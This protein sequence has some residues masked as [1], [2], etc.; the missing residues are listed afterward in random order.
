[1]NNPSQK[2][3]GKFLGEEAMLFVT[4]LWGS[5]FVIVKL[6]I[7]DVSTMLFIAIRF[8]IVCIFL[9]PIFLKFRKEFTKEAIIAGSILGLFLFGGFATQTVGLKFTSA[10]KSGF[11]TGSAVIMVPLLQIIIEKKKPNTGAIIGVILVF[12]GILFLSS[13]SN[14]IFSILQEFKDN[15]TIGDFLTL[16]CAIF[17]AFYIIYID[18][19]T[20]RHNFWLLVIMQM[21]VTSILAF[22]AVFISSFSGIEEIRIKFTDYLL[23]GLFYTSIFTTLITTVM[24]TKYQKLISPTKAGIIFSLEPVFAAI[25]AFFLLH[26]EITNLGYIGAGIIFAGLIISELFDTLFAKNG[27]AKS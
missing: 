4:L 1:M 20:K 15:F 25:F 8:S 6:S 3:N 13:N 23:F 24:Q 7:Q 21:S 22:M 5:T 26:E 18:V 27:H 10:T 11:L 17:F 16:I 19:F 9:I 14:S 2:S 12:I